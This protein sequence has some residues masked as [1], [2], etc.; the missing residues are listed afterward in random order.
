MKKQTVNI[1]NDTDKEALQNLFDKLAD[2]GLFVVPN[3]ELESWL[4]SL[5]AKGHGP[6]WLVEVFEKMG[7]DPNTSEYVKPSEGD[8]WEFLENISKWFFNPKRKG[9]PK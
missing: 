8:V 5:Q 7:E 3:G 1:L 6:S 2:Y 9:I 4:K